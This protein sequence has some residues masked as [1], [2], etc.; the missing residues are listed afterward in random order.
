MTD[1]QIKLAARAFLLSNIMV[2]LEGTIVATALPTMMADLNG[3]SL[4]SWVVTIY[5]LLM[6]I[7]API[8]TKLSERFGF[9][10]LFIL[11]T[12]IFIA[13]SLVE[14]LSQ[15]MT[16]LILARLTMGIGAGAMQQL[17]FVIYGDMFEPVA[18]RKAFGNAISAYSIASIIGPVIGGIIVESLGWRWVFF[19]NIPIG[20]LMIAVIQRNYFQNFTKNTKK[21]DFSGATFLSITVIAFMIALQTLGN[22]TIN[23]LFVG[24]LLAITVIFGLLFY[25][26]EKRAFDPIVPLD[27][28]KNRS[29]MMKNALMFLQYGYFGF[30]S[31]YFPIWGQGVMGHKAITAGLILIPASVFLV[32]GTRLAN[33]LIAKFGEKLTVS[34]GMIVMILAA[35]S[36]VLLT[37]TNPVSLLFVIGAVLGL[38]TG[39]VNGTTS[40]A[41]QETVPMQQMGAATALNALIRTMGTT[42]ILSGLALALNQT[43]ARSIKSNHHLTY[44]LINKISDST[45]LSEIPSNLV[46][47]L[48]GT[49]FS[50]LHTLSLIGLLLLVLALIVNQ[51][52][53][54]QKAND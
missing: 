8:W 41:I 19:I 4:M 36:L 26:A 45:K 3:I 6:A 21:I 24:I 33:P 48:R 39:I 15:D 32:V 28:F 50:G 43:F 5:M 1:K 31:N 34:I 42:L 13:S 17:P 54:W 2:G 47:A 53:P 18:R 29:L 25:R 52:D 46:H 23:Y 22:L 20:F 40:V 51:L 9:K 49:V 37:H 27:L 12:L 16:M 14:G 10:K 35:A 11:G 38:A 7:T 30:Y 44:G